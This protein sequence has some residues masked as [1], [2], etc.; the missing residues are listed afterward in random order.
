VIN[1]FLETAISGTETMSVFVFHSIFFLRDDAAIG[2]ILR[3]WI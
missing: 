3:V 2:E 1:S